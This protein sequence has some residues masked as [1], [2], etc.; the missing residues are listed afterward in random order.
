MFHNALCTT[1]YEVIYRYPHPVQFSPGLFLDGLLVVVT[2][3]QSFEN[4]F[5][6]IFYFI[7][8]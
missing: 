5:L 4:G 7:H 6:E 8:T 2:P 3:H 1:W